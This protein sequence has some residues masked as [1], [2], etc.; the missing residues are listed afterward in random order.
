M[1]LPY[2][3]GQG[4]NK[5][6]AEQLKNLSWHVAIRAM[7]RALL[8]MAAFSGPFTTDAVGVAKLF[9]QITFRQALESVPRWVWFAISARCPCIMFLG[10]TIARR[11]EANVREGRLD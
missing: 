7:A 4:G 9:E 3:F 10:A 1:Q 5:I 11:V 2:Y 6:A 8:G